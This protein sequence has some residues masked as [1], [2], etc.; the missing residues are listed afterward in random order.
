MQDI[1]PDLG[2]ADPLAMADEACRVAELSADPEIIGDTRMCRSWALAAT[3][4]AGAVLPGAERAAQ[5]GYHVAAGAF[6]PAAL[7]LARLGRLDELRSWST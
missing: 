6:V 3:P 1:A 5:L 2:F 4:D 7:A